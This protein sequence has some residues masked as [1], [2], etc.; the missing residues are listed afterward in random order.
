MGVRSQIRRTI[1]GR[2]RYDQWECVAVMCGHRIV[3]SI[4][5]GGGA[6]TLAPGGTRLITVR[7]AP[8]A[9]GSKSAVQGGR[10]DDRAT[11][12]PVAQRPIRG[13]P[14]KQG[15][16]PAYALRRFRGRLLGW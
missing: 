5:G 4:T 12:P 3:F 7:F 10:N 16:Y 13:V 2:A 14:S 8:T 11:P 6:F 9:G 1:T 15:L